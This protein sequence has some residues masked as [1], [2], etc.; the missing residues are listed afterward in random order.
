MLAQQG[1]SQ[2]RTFIE[3]RRNLYQFLLRI[4]QAPLDKGWVHAFKEYEDVG[5]LGELGSGGAGLHDFF[6]GAPCLKREATEFSRLFIGPGTL[7]AP[8]WESFYRSSEQ[9]LFDDVMYEVRQHF[10]REGLWFVKENNEPDDHL[11]VELEFMLTLI[12][13]GIHVEE[14]HEFFIILEK[15]RDF[16]SKHLGQWIGDFGKRLAESTDSKLYKGAAIL[17]ADF[18][19]NDLDFLNELVE[20]L[21]DAE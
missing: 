12:I 2:I 11:A 4:F 1:L 21:S 18:I 16:L 13:K 5:G 19:A 3:A 7:P 14:E 9:M 15:Q 8:P 17:A 6:S 10:H 20:G